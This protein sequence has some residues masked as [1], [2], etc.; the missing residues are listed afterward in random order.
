VYAPNAPATSS[1]IM[2]PIIQPSS[3]SEFML[4]V[5][6]PLSNS[7]SVISGSSGS[8]IEPSSYTTGCSSSGVTAGVGICGAV[9]SF[10]TPFCSQ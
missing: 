8:S 4:V 10:F 6:V 3:P 7:V 2:S 5:P 1:S 9:I